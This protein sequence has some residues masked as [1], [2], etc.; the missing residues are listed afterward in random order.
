MDSDEEETLYFGSCCS[1]GKSGKTVR[2]II[3][4]DFESPEKESGWGWG[5]VICNLPA[6]GAT[7]VKCDACVVKQVPTKF[8]VIGYPKD[9]KRMLI[10][11]VKEKI[12]FAH[13]EVLHM[14]DQGIPN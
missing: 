9:N 1:C 3:M 14:A 10:S 11:D 4:M 5:C 7:A 6:R 12:P 8:I 2:N 13:N